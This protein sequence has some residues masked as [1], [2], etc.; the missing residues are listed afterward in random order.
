ML[1]SEARID[2]ASGLRQMAHPVR[3]VAITGGKG[4]VG[5]TNVSVNLAVA[6][7]NQGQKV[8]LLD[9]DLGLANIDV[10]LGL[11]PTYNLAHVVNG[12]CS[13]EDIIIPGPAGIK[14]VPAA[15]GARA[16]AHLSPAE[17]AGLI[18]AFSKLG[19][20]LD[21]LLIDT[22]AGISDSVISFTRAAQEV[23][24]VV[25]DEPASITDAYA[26]IKILSRDHRLHRFHI[27]ANM[28][29]SIQEGRELY[30]KLVKVTNQFL[31]VTLEFSGVVPYDDCLR[32][33]VKKQSAVVSSY[34]RSKSAAAFIHLAQ[35]A[36]RWP[37]RREPGGHLEFFV[38][39]LVQSS[40]YVVDRPA[41]KAYAGDS[42][43]KGELS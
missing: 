24:M 1:M 3:V 43:S 8:M 20:A 10:L 2:Q 41:K 4:G 27:L 11:Q 5:K 15:S 28:A 18:H 26:L 38:E 29:R 21:V 12:E 9:A 42:Y 7:A 30:D 35:K 6:L 16:M 32:K 34:P 17:H 13:L 23:L 19:T 25:C 39:R 31:D 33:A 40:L 36:I 14:V 37:M 22:A